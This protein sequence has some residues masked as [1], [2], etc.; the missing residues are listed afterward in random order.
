M[1]EYVGQGAFLQGV[2]ARDLTDEEAREHGGEDALV[3]SGLYAGAV[4]PGEG[5]IASPIEMDAPIDATIL[6]PRKRRE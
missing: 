5:A 1:L 4:G 3:A 2:P 6:R